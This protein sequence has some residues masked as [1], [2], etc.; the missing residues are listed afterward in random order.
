MGAGRAGCRGARRP[1]P[2][3]MWRGVMQ[4]HAA[5][6]ARWTLAMLSP[7]SRMND[8]S[9]VAGMP[10][11]ARDRHE[12][13]FVEPHHLDEGGVLHQ[14]QERWSGTGTSDRR[15]CSSVSPSQARHGAQRGARR[16]TPRAGSEP[17]HRS[18]RSAKVDGRSGHGAK[19]SKTVHTGASHY[20]SAGRCGSAADLRGAAAPAESRADARS[21]LSAAHVGGARA[22]SVTVPTMSGVRLGDP[23]PEAVRRVVERATDPG[24]ASGPHRRER[25]GARCPA[26]LGG[27]PP[28]RRRHARPV[29]AAG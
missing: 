24:G 22:P 3:P 14:P 1:A 13:G 9:G 26:D 21:L 12:S 5:R 16:G 28:G 4:S 6:C 25:A 19:H 23:L 10:I 11:S 7:S 20:T 8:W 18:R 29:A 2:G 17:A 15:T 27:A